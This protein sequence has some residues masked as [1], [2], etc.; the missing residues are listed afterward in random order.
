MNEQ[1]LVTIPPKKGE[2]RNPNGR[3]KGIKNTLTLIRDFMDGKIETLKGT[4]VSRFHY[5]LWSM[6][7]TAKR[8][9][10]QLDIY[11]E[12][13]HEMKSWLVHIDPRTDDLKERRLLRI[14][15]RKRQQYE[16]MLQKVQAAHIKLSEFFLK[17]SGQ[18]LE[19]KEIE[20]KG[21]IPATIVTVT[22]EDL[23]EAVSEINNE[24]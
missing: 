10:K 7:E 14:A 17:S 6:Y 1:N 22:K 16:D 8:L 15:E 13:L 3:P 4:K 9:Q 24:L 19:K 12:E 20:N 11:E 2:V 5:L 18:Y 23:K 21:V